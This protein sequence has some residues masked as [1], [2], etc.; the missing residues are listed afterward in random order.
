MNAR[1]RRTKRRRQLRAHFAIER[2]ASSGSRDP[3]VDRPFV[4]T[5]RTPY[6]MHAPT[7]LNCDCWTEA[8]RP[9]FGFA[10]ALAK[11]EADRVA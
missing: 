7:Q 1:Q 2:A 8:G 6:C 4:L 5:P 11:W 3:L 9:L 10:Q